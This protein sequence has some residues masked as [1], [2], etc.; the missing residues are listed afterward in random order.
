[1]KKELS[2]KGMLMGA[3]LA[4]AVS[5][6]AM[7]EVT[8]STPGAIKG[9]DLMAAWVGAGAPNGAFSY[10]DM[11]GNSTSASFDADILP[12]FTKDDIWGDDTASCASCHSG[13]TEESLHEMDLTSYAGIMLGGDVLAKPP[14]VPLFGQSKIGATD[15]DWGHSKM[16]ERLRNNRMPPNVE[17]DITE[18]NRDG[19]CKV[20]ADKGC[21]V[22]MMAEW[23]GAGA[24]DDAS[25]KANILPMFTQDDYWGEDTASC[26]SCHSGN[27]EES[28]HEM[29]LTSYAGIMLGG[30]VLAKPP[31]V[32]LF[33][34]ST[35]GGT[36]Y[37]WGHSKMKG[38]LR[39]NRMP[40]NVEFD[41][42]EE[43]RDG[44]IVAHGSR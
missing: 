13:N 42:T 8:E 37:D 27:T 1:M 31:G 9:V 40:P 17:F 30:D 3:V 23:V 32:P 43:N 7:A 36:D 14:G 19:P 18:E 15:Y 10:K 2:L 34:Q 11:S 39:N 20:N 21:E 24:K 26:A 4:T 28:L 25:F 5:M 35:I 29:D 6:P 33:G 41:I 44:Q 12:L 16:K 38:R 22:G